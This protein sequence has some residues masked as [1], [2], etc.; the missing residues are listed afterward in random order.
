VLSLLSN[1]PSDRKTRSVAFELSRLRV[2]PPQCVEFLVAPEPRAL[3]RRFQ[4]SDRLVIDSQRHWEWMPV[5]A[6]MGE[7]KTRGIGEA[8]RSAV[9]DFSHYGERPDGSR[10]DTWGEQQFREIGRATIGGGCKFPYSRRAI[11][12]LGRT[13]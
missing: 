11:T 10:S 9:H 12:S 8:V 6:S 4:H 13:S 5:L 1:Q 7:G 2:Q 3:Y